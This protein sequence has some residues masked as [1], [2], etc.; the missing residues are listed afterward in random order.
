[1]SMIFRMK[2]ALLAAFCVLAVFAAV[3]FVPHGYGE[4]LDS[5]DISVVTSH[6][7]SDT[8]VLLDLD[9]TVFRSP[10]SLGSAQ[11]FYHLVETGKASGLDRASAV[12][13]YYPFY[14]H[15]QR[16]CPAETCDPRMADLIRS[17]QEQGY[18]VLGLTSRQPVLAS[19][20]IGFLDNLGINFSHNPWNHANIALAGKAVGCWYCGVIFAHDLNDKGEIL[21]QFLNQVDA[22]V[23]KKI[24]FV[25]DLPH[26]IEAVQRVAE[27][28]RL[29]YVGLRY[30]IEDERVAA[31]DPAIAEIQLAYLDS[32]LPD[33]VAEKIA[34]LPE[35]QELLLSYRNPAIDSQRPD[36]TLAGAKSIRRTLPVHDVPVEIRESA[37]IADLLQLADEN[38]LVVF[39]L[40]DTLMRT[41]STMGGDVWA[42]K[43]C[44]EAVA[45]G[46]TTEEALDRL[47]P[48]WHQVLMRTPVEPVESDT[49]RVIAELQRRGC[50]MMGLTARYT[51]MAYPTIGALRSIFIDF[52]TNS[53]ASNDFTPRTPSPSKY[54]DGVVF[55]GLQNDKAEVLVQ[56][57]EQNTVEFNKIVFIDDKKKNVEGMVKAAQALNKSYIGVWYRAIENID[58]PYNS[59]VAKIQQMLFG[60][61][62]PDA[63]VQK[64]VDK[65]TWRSASTQTY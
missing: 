10:T 43:I 57:L 41:A 16:F 4:V 45:S 51:E 1:M 65:D 50:K 34:L 28:R 24:V 2:T 17:W 19:T 21:H 9:N 18:A 61:V 14:A 23:I 30:G 25:D 35:A 12:T 56:F 31:F 40:N 27:S 36:R 15:T 32:V 63:I 59:D 13:A 54:I 20:V 60:K 52:S 64:L 62:V 37:H 47:V 33:T 49:A 38:T 11:W 53:I 6:I 46:L 22:S 42:Q 3:F 39:D 5:K 29:A 44:K 55:A 8:L 58:V 7:G 48:F 26:N